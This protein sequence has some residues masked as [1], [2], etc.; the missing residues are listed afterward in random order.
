VKTGAGAKAIA[1]FRGRRAGKTRN[2]QSKRTKGTGGNV[3][4]PLERVMSLDARSVTLRT[5]LRQVEVC[6]HQT[7]NVARHL[8][9]LAS[10]ISK[11]NQLGFPCPIAVSS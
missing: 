7:L 4:P 8:F 6:G 10:T 3:K 5:D 9:N 2:L 1:G 11:S